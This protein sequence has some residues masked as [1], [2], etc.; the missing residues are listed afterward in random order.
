MKYCRNCGAQ[1]PDDAKTCYLCGHDIEQA[2]TSVPIDSSV[3]N[4]SPL[5]MKWHKFLCYFALWAGA[6][7]N[8][9]SG[10]RLMTGA[11]YGAGA[12]QVYTKIPQL[13]TIDTIAGALS[14]AIALLGIITAIRLIKF[15]EN[16]PKLLIGLYV[17]GAIAGLFYT[18]AAASVLG[19]L[20]ADARSIISSQ[21][22]SLITSAVMVI[23]NIVYYKKREFMFIN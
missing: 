14:I 3:P 13:K 11:A 4:A 20:G 23:V 12:A 7:V 17:A 22:P 6:A 15:R 10:I 1:I 5:P 9:F 8:A 16:A 18:I 2:E 21:I 19:R